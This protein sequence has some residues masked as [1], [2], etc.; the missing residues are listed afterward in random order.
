MQHEQKLSRLIENE[1]C[2]S[3][4]V[5]LQQ[6]KIADLHLRLDHQHTI[7]KTILHVL[8]QTRPPNVEELLLKNEWQQKMIASLRS[9]L[10]TQDD[11]VHRLKGK[12]EELHQLGYSGCYCGQC[13][14]VSEGSEIEWEHPS[15]DE[16]DK[17]VS[18]SDATVRES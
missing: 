8:E 2:L 11:K 12:L 10:Q 14:C 7:N 3:Q 6:Q 17:V 4:T 18:G 9:T 15:S 16:S 13:G 5:S 1:R